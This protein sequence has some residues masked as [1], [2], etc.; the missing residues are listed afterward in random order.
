MS[1]AKILAYLD[2]SLVEETGVYQ[3][4]S[5]FVG[6]RKGRYTFDMVLDNSASLGEHTL[7]LVPVDERYLWIRVSFPKLDLKSIVDMN[8]ISKT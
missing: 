8:L 3:P 1:V 2:D 6:G 5:P 4:P 7:A